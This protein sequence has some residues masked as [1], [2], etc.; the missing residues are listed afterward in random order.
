MASAVA[1]SSKGAQRSGASMTPSSETRVDS[2]SL[3]TA[4][5]PSQTELRAGPL[6]QAPDGVVGNGRPA[7]PDLEGVLLTG[8]HVEAHLYARLLRPLGER[9]AVV[10]ERLVDATPGYK[11]AAA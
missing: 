4:P 2:I 5:S 3:R 8:E 6:G 10:N 9:P 7:C 1:S 11:A